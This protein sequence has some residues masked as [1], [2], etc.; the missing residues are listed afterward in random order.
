MHQAP[1]DCE[2]LGGPDTVSLRLVSQASHAGALHDVTW[3]LEANRLRGDS[4]TLNDS[5]P[6]PHQVDTEVEAA[7][8]NT[9]RKT[10]AELCVVRVPF[11][12][13]QAQA[14][15]GYTALQVK[16]RDGGEF[17][18]SAGPASIPAPGKLASVER[19]QWDRIVEPFPEI[20][21]PS[22]D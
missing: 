3:D 16:E 5:T 10:L 7:R 21:D 2:P 1:T 20:P 4:Y 11:D 18:I 12:E 17:W 8:A 22:G 14:P 15:G 13:D 19:E 9:L 6:V